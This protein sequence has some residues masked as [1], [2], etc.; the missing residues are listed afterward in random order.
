MDDT[1]VELPNSY[2]FVALLVYSAKVQL[3]SLANATENGLVLT[4]W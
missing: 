2:D 1:F 4:G 3:H